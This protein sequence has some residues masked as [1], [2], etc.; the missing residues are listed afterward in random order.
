MSGEVRVCGEDAA[1]VRA[2]PDDASEQVTQVLRGEPLTVEEE[3]GDWA[4]IR[5]AYDYPG[6]IRLD[7]AGT[8]PRDSPW[9]VAPRASSRRRPDRGS[10]HATSARRTS[11]AA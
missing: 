9:D 1:P 2:E 4:R 10:A 7:L 11:G 5:T 6:W 8:C 3:R